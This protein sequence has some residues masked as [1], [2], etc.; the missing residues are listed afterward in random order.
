MSS[1]GG[2]V[3]LVGA[4]PGDPMLITLRAASILARAD[5]IV[6]DRLANPA[7][8]QHCRRDAERVFVGK[9]AHHHAVPQAEINRMLVEFASRGLHVC[10][11]KGGDPFVF[12]RGGEEAQALA[13]A[14][15]EWEYVPGISSAVAAPGYAGIPVTHRTHGSAFAVVT[16]HHDP[17]RG[18]E[19]SRWA[20][21]PEPRSTLVI[22]MGAE[23]LN[24]LVDEL[25]TGGWAPETPAALVSRGTLRSQKVLLGTLRDLPEQ[26]RAVTGGRPATL[27]PATL[28]VGEVAGLSSELAWHRPGS[29]HQR[30][31]VVTRPES[32][33]QPLV[34][35]LESRGAVVLSLPLIRLRAVEPFELET[36]QQHWD[37]VVFTS[38]NAVRFLREQLR[39]CCV[40]IRSLPATARIAAIG[41]ETARVADDVGL[42]V[43]FVPN[44]MNS[45]G[46]LREFPEPVADLKI[47]LPRAREG[48]DLLAREW[49]ARGAVIGVLPTYETVELPPTEQQIGSV[50]L[51]PAADA[52]V[53]AS[54]SAVRALAAALTAEQRAML[55]VA[56]I[57]DTTGREA[58]R[59]GFGDLAIAED[60][61]PAGVA[62]AL[63][64][65]LAVEQNGGTGPPEG[66]KR[67]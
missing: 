9:E 43:S 24:A 58:R 64:G 7:L 52:V 38:A 13:A 40:D 26:V 34:N 2:K 62:A 41:R 46:L 33:A 55:R 15:I 49:G 30:R 56:C 25:L 16:G 28:I 18:F 19:V 39:A 11:L 8:L 59:L 47:L 4:G 44:E 51:E 66:S 23:R 67:E 22:L 61:S 54:G 5:V 36:L 42:R 12:G 63:E 1:A 20:V 21:R 14:G 3:S 48:R 17:A 10:R 50:I 27:S 65:L 37:W 32:Q 29:L 6:Y 35:E 45:E 53:L 57:G 60:P 31:I